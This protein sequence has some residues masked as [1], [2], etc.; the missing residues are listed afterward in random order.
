MIRRFG[1]AG[2]ATAVMGTLL[3]EVADLLERVVLIDH[4][5]I[6]PAAATDDV[7][8]GATT[9]SGPRPRR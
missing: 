2:A 8:A 9:V 4:G 3:G 7:R 5:R 1:M 6:V